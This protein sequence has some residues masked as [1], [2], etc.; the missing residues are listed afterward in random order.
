MSIKT[1]LEFP[2]ILITIGI[3]LLIISIIIIIIAIKSD[4]KQDFKNN[5]ND[6]KPE[7]EPNNIEESKQEELPPVEPVQIEEKPELPRVEPSNS[8]V[9]VQDEEEIELL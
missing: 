9:Q 7:I 5:N 3:V 6:F 1:F 8:N 4:K 2:G